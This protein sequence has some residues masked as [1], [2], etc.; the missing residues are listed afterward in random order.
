MANFLVCKQMICGKKLE[1]ALH[2][3]CLTVAAPREGGLRRPETNIRKSKLTPQQRANHRLIEFEQDVV[4]VV[5][6]T[7]FYIDSQCTKDQS[8]WRQGWCHGMN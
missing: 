2:S 5:A 4:V 6:V 3:W 8:H 7:L 1:I